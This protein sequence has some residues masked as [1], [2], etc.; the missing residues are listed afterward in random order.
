MP[1]VQGDIFNCNCIIFC[2]FL[3]LCPARDVGAGGC[4]TRPG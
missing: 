3:L 1:V 4:V 2:P